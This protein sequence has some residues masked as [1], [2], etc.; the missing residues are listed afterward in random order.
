MF[1]NISPDVAVDT[2]AGPV[3]YGMLWKLNRVI[4]VMNPRHL[5]SMP[6]GD[7][8]GTD[9]VFLHLFCSGPW[10]LIGLGVRSGMVC[11]T[12]DMGSV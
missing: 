3:W 4:R 2:T 6:D 9:C 1:F 11:C 10:I 5:T 8:S 7:V 12:V